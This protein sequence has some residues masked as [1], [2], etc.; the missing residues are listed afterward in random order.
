MPAL[1]A[2]VPTLVLAPTVALALALPP[3]LAH[4]EPPAP[5]PALAPAA[6]PETDLAVLG[7]ELAARAFVAPRERTEVDVRGAFRIRQEALINLDLDRGLDPS[8]RPVFPVPLGGGQVLD[9]GDLRLRTDLSLRAPG[10]G[11]A[12]HARLDV[13][14]NLPWGGAPE[15]GT[16]RAPT[17]AASPGQ[18]PGAIAVERVWGEVLTPLGVLAAGRMGAHWG[19]GMAAHGGDCDECDGGDAADRVAFASPLLG[20]V[21]AV[22]WDV[23]A[24]GPFAPR[25]D[26]RRTIDL[27]PSDDATTWTAA[28]LRTRAPAARARRAAAGLATVEYGVFASHRRQARDVPAHYLPVAVPRPPGALDASDLMAR[29]FAATTGGVW[30]RLTTARARVELEAVYARARVDQPS[31]LPGVLLDQAATSDQFGLAIETAL[32]LGAHAVGV[33]AGVASGDDAP[34]FGAFPAPGAAAPRPGD[35]DGPQADP[36]GDTTVDNFRFHPDYKIDRILFAELVGTVTDAIYLRPHVRLTLAEVGPGRLDLTVAA[37]ASWAVAPS[38]TPSGAR[39]LG[40]ELDPT[41]A[42]QAEGFRAALDYAVLR[43]GA[44]FD[45]PVAGLDAAAAQLVRLRLGYVF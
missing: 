40:L 19:L 13:L 20:H 3:A 42:Y 26:E 7:A 31:L 29:G 14:D 43:P 34:G 25:P 12:V 30:F 27:E 1:S 44:A 22:A 32:A 37:V 10:A 8:G 23:A 41:L 16:G 35:L 5:A 4:A 9:G 28:V 2:L 38:S 39:H 17:P 33:D 24:S 36:P 45:N 11:V 21:V 18:T 15:V 6:G